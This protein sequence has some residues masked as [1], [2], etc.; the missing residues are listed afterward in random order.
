[1]SSLLPSGE[2]IYEIS[3]VFH[4]DGAYSSYRTPLVSRYCSKEMSYNFS[5][6]NK[7]TIWRKLWI[8]LAKSQKQL[9]YSISDEQISQMVDNLENI[10]FDAV[11]SEEHKRKHDVVAHIVEFSRVCPKAA[12]I[13]HLGA[14]SA[15]VVDNGDLIVMRDGLDLLAKKLINCIS[16]LSSFAEKYRCLSTLGYTHMQPA[17]P[18]TVGKRACM[19]LQDLV[20][21]MHN[22]IR[23]KES[24]RFL[25]VK[26]TTGTQASFLRLFNG[27]DEKVEQ[28]DYMVAKRAGFDK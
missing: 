15:Y 26:G 10:D 19:W 13:I 22:F 18:T 8:I 20:M 6:K 12:P 14:T 27:D 1:M 7:I 4:S 3:D 9:G 25:G 2:G 28:L 21:D 23:V 17:Q 11:R 16:R 5:E 24:L